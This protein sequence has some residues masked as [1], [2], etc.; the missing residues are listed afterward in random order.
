MR[1][2]KGQDVLSSEPAPAHPASRSGLQSSVST[3][4]QPGESENVRLLLRWST[5]QHYILYGSAFVEKGRKY[6]S[7]CGKEWG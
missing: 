2:D 5:G 6:G 7:R 1:Q 4:D 3:N